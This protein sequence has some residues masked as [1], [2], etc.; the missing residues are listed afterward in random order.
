MKQLE[1]EIA[2]SQAQKD[3]ARAEEAKRLLAEQKTAYNSMLSQ[4]EQLEQEKR[5]RELQLEEERK[6]RRLA[7]QR[8]AKAAAKKATV[9]VP[10]AF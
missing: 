6:Q 4:I 1:A 7:E 10:P 5:D 2:N 9:Y 3:Y 8:S